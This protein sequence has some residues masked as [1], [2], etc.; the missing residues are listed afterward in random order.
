MLITIASLIAIAYLPGAIAFRLPF[1][2]RAK[3]AALPAEERLFWS[4][5]ISIIVTTTV[6]FALAAMSAYSLRVLVWCN[7]GLAAVLALAS[8]GNLRLGATA[9]RPGW[10]AAIPAVL[11]AAGVW[12]YFAVPAAEYVLGGRD[13]GVYVSEGIQIA[14]RQSLVTTDRR[15]SG[16]AGIDARSVFSVARGSELLQRSLHGVSPARSGFRCGDRPV[17]AG[18]SGL[19][20]DRVRV[21]WSDRHSA[22]DRMVGDSG[23]PDRV[24]RGMST[25][26]PPSG[27]GGGRAALRPR[28]TDVVR[29]LSEF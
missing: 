6:A 19:D 17:P 7:V 12:M 11:I 10:T 5:I 13:P 15:C 18:L 28:H 27:G 14:Q 21:G 26:R 29:A 20:C 24:L 9:R 4:V 16:R 23:R 1:A 3:R 2:D 8:L 25:H 22:S